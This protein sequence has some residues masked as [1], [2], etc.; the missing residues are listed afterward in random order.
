MECIVLIWYIHRFVNR[1]IQFSVYVR[2]ASPVPDC[3]I[4][5]DK[6]NVRNTLILYIHFCE[7]GKDLFSKWLPNYLAVHRN[8]QVLHSTIHD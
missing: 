1:T 4:S 2:F 6:K 8:L 5:C 3:I 7:P